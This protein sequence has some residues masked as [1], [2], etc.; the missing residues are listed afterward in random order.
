M[1][2]RTR[3]LMTMQK[4]LH[5]RDDVDRRYVSRNRGGKG[6]ASIEDS[7]DASIQQI[8]DNIEKHKGGLITS[9]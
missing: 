2:H 7:V 6:L 5:P 4:A 9:I 8:D 3:K 1:K